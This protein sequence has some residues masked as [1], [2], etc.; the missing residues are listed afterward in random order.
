MIDYKRSLSRLAVGS[1]GLLLV[2]IASACSDRDA[3]KTSEQVVL[4]SSAD[5]YLLNQVVELFEAQTGIQV[6]V[7]TD[8]EATKTTGLAQRLL[9]EKDE[10]RA[11]VW[12]SS[13]PSRTIE[14]TRAGVFAPMDM[15]S[16]GLVDAASGPGDQQGRW[17]G[18][19]LRARAFAWS[20]ARLERNEVP[21][22]LGEL[23][24]ARFK[25]R[26][27]MA[28]PR[29]GTTQSHMAAL[30]QAWG[31]EGLESW[32]EQ[33]RSNGLRIYTSNS[34][35]VRGIAHGEID[36]GLTDTDDVWVAKR[37]NWPVE[38]AYEAMRDD[39]DGPWLSTG[40]LILP[41]T[42][43]LVA[44]GPN[45]DNGEMLVRFLLS[46]EVETLIAES[47]SHNFPVRPEL[48]LEAY[49]M[50]KATMQVDLERVADSLDD[51]M[52][53]SVRTFGLD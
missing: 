44:G 11:D 40:A 2:L 5:G 32:L 37:N 8:T 13:E 18:F 3:T 10:P 25:G 48:R 31:S 47:D 16:P 24:Q 4:Y 53:I 27:G 46:E 22:T 19:A 9:M 28:D 39:A 50:P 1:L 7:I 15:Q 43:A 41:N 12:W 52:A 38:I 34:A 35:V 6:R 30:M 49:P 51:A 33:M 29:F 21:Q 20:T 17:A 26:V 42:V 36:I 45:A 23:T 14:L